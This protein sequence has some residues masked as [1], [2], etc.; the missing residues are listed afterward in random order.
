MPHNGETSRLA[1]GVDDIFVIG[2]NH[3][4]ALVAVRERLAFS[5][6]RIAAILPEMIV[7][8]ERRVR[9]VYASQRMQGAQ[10]VQ[11]EAVILSTCNRTEI[12]VCAPAG[13][14][15]AVRG[16]LSEYGQLSL[17][18]L[19][20]VLYTYRGDGAARH[21]LRVAAGLDSLVIGENEIL[22]QVKDAFQMAQA[23]ETIGPILSAL[24]RYALQTGKRVRNETDIGHAAL[25]VATIVVELAQGDCGSLT[26]R[27]ALLIGAGKMSSLTARA[28]VQAG[29]RCVLVANR[30][31]Q[32]AEKLARSLGGRAVHFDALAEN[33]IQADI[34]ICSTGAPHI[35]LHVE[36]VLAALAAR[37]DQPLLVVDLAVPR[38]ADPAIGELPGVRLADIDDLETQVQTHHPLAVAVRQAAEAI[39]R[40]ELDDF[41][42]W[43][44]ARLSVPVIR[45]LRA[46]AD[47]IRQAE[48]ERTLHR[49]GDLTPQQQ[50]AIEAMGR[51]IVGKLLHDPIV[52]LKDPPSGISRAQYLDL[53]Q[54]LFGLN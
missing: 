21:L 11:A 27:T 42:V 36:D 6:E 2:L 24:F 17:S 41:R 31:Y 1:P 16:Y 20:A 23:A 47:D 15:S 7:G 34:V 53:T 8:V 45:A 19:D 38:D 10:G 35:V 43:S 32:R 48:L 29:L 3:K 49:L 50:R 9:G 44:D 14:E 25:S 26:D 33:L 54:T 4:V 22:G 13:A 51:A 30:T 12:Y 18:A 37:P 52:H 39:V 40:D 5:A 28:L 46:R